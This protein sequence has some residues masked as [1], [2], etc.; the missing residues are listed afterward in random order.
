[1]NRRDPEIVGFILDDVPGLNYTYI[2]LT[3][4]LTV[5]YGLNGAG[6]STVLTAIANF[7]AG[8]DGGASALVHVPRSDSEYY[9][10]DLRFMCVKEW[11]SGSLPPTFDDEGATGGLDPDTFEKIFK[12]TLLA[13][14]QPYGAR[15]RE[16]DEAASAEG[17]LG[18]IAREML[19]QRLLQIQ[20]SGAPGAP[21]WKA[22]M[23][24]REDPQYPYISEELTAFKQAAGQID[25]GFEGTQHWIAESNL[26]GSAHLRPIDFSPWSPILGNPVGTFDRSTNLTQLPYLNLSLFDPQGENQLRELLG[27][28]HAGYGKSDHW[29]SES[30]SLSHTVLERAT[31]VEELANQRYRAIM[32]DAPALRLNVREPHEW[33][34]QEPVTWTVGPQDLPL[35][36]LSTGEHRWAD[37]AIACA[38]EDFRWDG[39]EW[40]SQLAL[41]DEPEA[42]LHRSAESFM[43]H[44]LESFANESG[45][46]VIVA[47]H[48]PEL[49]NA[50]SAQL[51]EV[52]RQD[53]SKDAVV[54]PLRHVD[55][56]AL[57]DLGLTPSDLLRRQKGF[58]LVEGE[59]DEVLLRTWVG[60][61]LAEMRVE[62]LPLR[63]AQKLPTTIESRVLFDFSDAM[64]FVLLDNLDARQVRNAWR[65]ANL[66]HQQEGHAAAGGALRALL[67]SKT[68]EMQWLAQWLSR[69]LERGL[70]ERVVP[71]GLSRADIIEYLPA[72]GFVPLA[73]SWSELRAEHEDA[74][75][76]K[77]TPKDFKAWLTHA[78]GAKITAA[79]IQ[80]L[81]MDTPTP[82]EI[83]DFVR[84][85][86][87][88]L[89]TRNV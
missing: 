86:T 23:V 66:I 62:I 58:L 27:R 48:S 20:P 36:A 24:A 44:A 47:S 28:K 57:N 87:E 15:E 31:R 10:P 80:E 41:V 4:G 67:G 1:M 75:N 9:P 39:R 59:H 43:A 6:K 37:W 38:K 32:F 14:L 46:Y 29:D 16:A 81:A 76:A 13:D 45:R 51:L 70:S 56:D 33:W 18:S 11:S 12:E 7:F 19:D 54:A 49:I 52:T 26:L 89:K 69:A 71:T 73:S 22:Y 8:E 61:E 68:T 78:K 25:A 50:R 65:E 35:N 40:P 83:R 21:S 42:A 53:K 64:V 84:V 34:D 77:G 88:I 3:P 5:L 85:S 30:N 55:L 2:P 17:R 82:E 60:D 79:R 74:K 63:G 72:S